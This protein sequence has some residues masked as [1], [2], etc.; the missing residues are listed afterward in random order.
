MRR[1]RGRGGASPRPRLPRII[2]SARMKMIQHLSLITSHPLIPRATQR[3]DRRELDIPTWSQRLNPTFSFVFIEFD[4]TEMT[5]CGWEL[6]GDSDRLEKL[7]R[8]ALT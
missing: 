2:L 7:T 5:E 1:R 4:R 6:F 3:I 8:S